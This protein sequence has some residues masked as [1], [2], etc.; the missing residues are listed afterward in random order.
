[1]RNSAEDSQNTVPT[2]A[3]LS[4]DRSPIACL[5]PR[6]TRQ[7][8]RAEIWADVEQ[9]EAHRRYDS[10]VVMHVENRGSKSEAA[11]SVL[12]MCA[13]WAARWSCILAAVEERKKI[14]K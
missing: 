6:N 11:L 1:M 12:T 9:P 2:Q 13:Q 4:Y 8:V 14:I 3:F 5:S 10:S 7:P